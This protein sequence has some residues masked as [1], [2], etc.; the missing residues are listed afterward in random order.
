MDDLKIYFATYNV[1]TSSPEQSLLEMLSLSSNPKND[2]AT[3]DFYVIGLQEVSAQPVKLMIDAFND[4]PWTRALKE[5]LAPRNYIKLK[6]IRLQG[7]VLSVYALRKHLLNVRE[8]ESNYTRTGL[9]GLWGNKGAVSIRLGIYGCTICFVNAHLSAHDHQLDDRI[10]D[11][12]TIVK[13]QE[14]HVSGNNTIFFHDYIFWMGDLNFRLLENFDRS[15]EEIE[16]IINKGNIDELF[17]HD[18]LRSVMQKK[19]AFSELDEGNPL[20]PPTFKFEVGDSKY[21]HKRRPAWTDRILYKVH[22]NN[23]DNIT[24]HAEQKSYISHPQY[25]LSDH[26]PVTSEFVIKTPQLTKRLATFTLIDSQVLSEYGEEVVKFD[27]I[28]NWWDN[29]ENCI[30]FEFLHYHKINRDDWIGVY[31]AD[32]CCLDEYQTY[33]Y[34]MKN[35]SPTPTPKN[36]V[37]PQMS[38]NSS[39]QNPEGFSKKYNITFSQPSNKH[40]GLFRLIYVSETEDKV[41]SVLG[42]SDAFTISDKDD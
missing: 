19:V 38:P 39:V 36:K 35:S 33:E 27:K 37:S 1:G 23:Y 5:I 32:F 41:R 34:V 18:Q 21:D 25:T 40:D 17:K 14:F 6:T 29:E 8:I 9:S 11:Y 12:N 10:E 16:R 31:K 20:F 4:D 7:L 15:P 26:K 42:I 2:K 3:P 28:S 24:L 30:S 22:P 13:D